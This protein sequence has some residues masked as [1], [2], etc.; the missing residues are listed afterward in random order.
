MDRPGEIGLG[1][2]DHASAAWGWA[3]TATLAVATWLVLH[4]SLIGVAAFG[5]AF[6][7]WM[8]RRRCLRR[9]AAL[10][11]LFAG[12]DG[13]WRGIRGD[14][15]LR[16]TLARAVVL[17]GAILASL[18]GPGGRIAVTVTRR[19]AGAD[20]FRRLSGWLRLVQGAARH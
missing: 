10:G 12:P 3:M 6:L 13:D 8:W 14:A 1:G 19:S 16:L 7:S 20:A 5:A 17:P 2:S 11:D 9:A 15:E 18:D 4:L